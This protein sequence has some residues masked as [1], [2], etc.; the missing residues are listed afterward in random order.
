MEEDS[1][2]FIDPT[3][4]NEKTEGNMREA[5]LWAFHSLN[6][7]CKHCSEVGGDYIE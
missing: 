4:Y 3:Y 6:E 2:R 1:S 7:R 5:F